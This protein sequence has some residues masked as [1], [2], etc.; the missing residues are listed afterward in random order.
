MEGKR[1]NRPPNLPFVLI[2]RVI[3]VGRNGTPFVDD[4]VQPVLH[5]RDVIPEL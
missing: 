1:Q 4:I 2:D 3:G 5:P